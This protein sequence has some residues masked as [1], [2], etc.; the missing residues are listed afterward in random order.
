VSFDHPPRL[1]RRRAAA[2][3]LRDRWAMRC[4]EQTLAK[5]ATHG[6]GSEFHRYGRDVVYAVE[7]LDEWALSRL[8]RPMRSTSETPPLPD[9][10]AERSAAAMQSV[11]D[12]GDRSAAPTR[13][14]FRQSE[15]SATPVE[16]P[17]R[18][19]TPSPPARGEGVHR[20]PT[21]RRKGT[22]KGIPDAVTRNPEK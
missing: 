16:A 18:S 7:K 1:L 17:S 10:V 12:A 19:G 2:Q 11:P 14:D 21:K 13:C 5:Y 3:H 4:S 20:K 9:A 8:S 22:E 6:C 15:T